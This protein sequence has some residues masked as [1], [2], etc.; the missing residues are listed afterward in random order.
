[1]ASGLESFVTSTVSVVCQDG[2]NFVGTL[3]GFDQTVNIILE[4][5]IE[6]VYSLNGVEQVV[7]GLH[8]VR[9]DNVAII[10]QIDDKIDSRLDFPNIRAEP[11]NPVVY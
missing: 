9:G 11:L 10:G 2:R 7:L 4:D 1:M 5:T 8:I 3:K 6:R